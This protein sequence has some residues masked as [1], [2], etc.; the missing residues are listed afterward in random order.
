MPI[1]GEQLT[2][3]TWLL[4]ACGTLFGCGAGSSQLVLGKRVSTGKRNYD[5]YFE[6]VID[7]SEKVEALDSDL[8]PLRQPLTE[9]LNVDVDASLPALLYATKKRAAKL[10]NYGV[11]AN[12]QLTANPTVL[13]ERGTMREDEK[14]EALFKAVQEAAV[15]AMATYLEYSTMLDQ[16]VELDEKREPLAERVE[17]LDPNHP[18]RKRIEVEL[19]GAGKV[20]AN[21]EKKL[22][23]DTRTVAHFLVGLTDAVDTG[24]L[25][26]QATKCNE[27]LENAS[28]PRW[29]RRSGGRT[30]PRPR[31]AGRP[32]PRPAPRPAPAGGGGDFDM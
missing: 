14:D 9:I 29:G 32:R 15:R 3:R 17:R 2:R 30:R 10:K 4:F 1:T 28:K 22:L 27:A 26:Q 7:I 19:V 18:Q 31:P 25:E 24:A 12:L 23:R 11:T 21:A 5:S 16:I 6:D 20:L 13:I 8:F